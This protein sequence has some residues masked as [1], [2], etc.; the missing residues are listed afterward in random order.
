M[1]AVTEIYPTDAIAT[2]EPWSS[3]GLKK[4]MYPTQDSRR[5][6]KGMPTP[7]IYSSSAD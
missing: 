4:P 1:P 3:E 7:S 5:F 6:S 2:T